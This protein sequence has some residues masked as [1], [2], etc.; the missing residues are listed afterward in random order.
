[1]PGRVSEMNDDPE[2]A[3]DLNDDHPHCCIFFRFR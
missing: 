1:M 2:L 3:Y